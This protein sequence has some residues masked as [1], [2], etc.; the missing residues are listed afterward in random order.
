MNSSKEGMP[1]LA[2]FP[3]YH[4]HYGIDQ[5]YFNEPFLSYLAVPAIWMTA[6]I[7]IFISWYKKQKY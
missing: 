4:L 5:L 1:W 7:F 2:V 6:V 3:N